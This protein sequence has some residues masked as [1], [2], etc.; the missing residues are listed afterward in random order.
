MPMSRGLAGSLLASVAIAVT[1]TT[2]NAGGFAVREQSASSQGASFAGSAAGYDLSSMYWN[3]AAVTVKDGFN[4]EAHGS[5]ILGDS[6]IT[7][8]SFNGVPPALAGLDSNSG[9]IADPALVTSSYYNYQINPS[10]YL[11]LSLNAPFGLTTKPENDPYAGSFLARTS[12]VFT[13]NAA[14]TVGYKVAPGLS[15][16]VGLQI[17]Y[18][19]AKLSRRVDPRSPGILG[20]VKG[21]DIGFGATVGVLFEPTAWTKIGL[22][23][24]SAIDHE[25]EGSFQLEG[26]AAKDDVSADVTLPELVTLSLRQGITNDFTLLGTVEWTN[27]SRV[28]ELRVVCKTARASCPTSGALNGQPVGVGDTVSLEHL[29]Y[30]DGWFFSLGGEYQWS[31]QLLLRTGLAYE[32]SPIRNAQDRGLRIPDNDRIWA[33]VG[34]TYDLSDTMSLDF[35]YTHIFVD[36][37]KIDRA[38]AAFPD[39]P[40]A[41]EAD[42]EQSVDIISASF[43]MKL[44]G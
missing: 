25:L 8:T 14:P 36:E 33:S 23:F 29:N 34:A 30:E 15:V 12:K 5:V 18:I 13:L 27:W 1:V 37:G 16:G 32:I 3:P 38:A 21:D 20:T 19:D 22:G 2:A 4:S 28:Q 35:A 31:S 43:K 26:V 40:F 39:A 9:N 44:G 42:V 11:G 41:L 6:E 17:Q 24:R 7:T 10:T